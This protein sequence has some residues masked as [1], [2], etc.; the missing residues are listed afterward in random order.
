MS[1]PQSLAA[2]FLECVAGRPE[3]EALRA[4]AGDGWRSLTWR[5]TEA[6]AR[7]LAGGLLSLGVQ[8][9]D[10]VAIAATTRLEWVLADLAIAL[11]GG[12]T[13]TV[14]P[15]TRSGD[16][17]HI[18]SDSG[19]VVAIVEDTTQVDK[20]V[21]N[22][23]GLTDLRTVVVMDTD[24]LGEPDADGTWLEGWVISFADLAERGRAYLEDNPGAVDDV[25][26]KLTLDHLST[27]IYTSGTTGRPKGVELTH[28]NWVLLGESVEQCGVVSPDDL[29]FLWLP[30]S[31]VFGKLLLA[32]QYRVGFTSVVDGRMD[33]IVEN[34]AVVRPTLMGAAP[35]IFEKVYARVTSTVREEGGV[36]AKIFDWAFGVGRQCVRLEQAGRSVPPHLAVQRLVAD[37]L[38]FS[39]IRQRLGGR[40]R[41]LVSGSAALS[42]E[43]AEWFAAAGMPILEGYGLTETGAASCVNRPGA[44]RIGTVGQP[45]AGVEVKIAD[46]GEILIRGCGVMRRYRNM[47]E[48]TAA[49]L[50]PDG[51]F[52]TGDIG[53]IDE[54]GAVKITDR[55]NDMAKTSGGKFIAPSAIEGSLK[56]AN[57]LIGQAVVIA[58][59]RNFASVL[60]ALDADAA[61]AWGASHGVTADQVPSHPQIQEEISTTI[62]IV[63]G[64]LNR[65][66][67]IKRFQILPRELD[68]ESGELTPSLKIK[69]PVVIKHYSEL[70]EQMYRETPGSRKSGA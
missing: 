10:R 31:H 47:P 34:L 37:R 18:M 63:N 66:E 17:H 57:G 44:V 67:T 46:D 20:L 15:T 64:N 51:W 59:G 49:V 43:I 8:I 70:I 22:R 55:K 68:V 40:L 42:P 61:E 32:A 1:E 11:A 53:E 28:R 27:L 3:I 7:I 38:V 21:E 48:A 45:L 30:L 4:P 35:R 23:G 58:D 62:D 26:A 13:T 29:H 19:S 36:K 2:A 24:G 33:K 56:A 69:R 25:V 9:E 50:E 5:Q 14:Y 54:A 52:H 60:I 41:S 6:E 65:W 16:V 12:A 39:T